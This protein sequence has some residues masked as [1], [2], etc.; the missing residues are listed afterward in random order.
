MLLCCFFPLFLKSDCIFILSLSCTFHDIRP[1]SVWRDFTVS[2]Q[3]LKVHKAT[4]KSRSYTVNGVST[5]PAGSSLAQHQ[6]YQDMAVITY[7]AIQQ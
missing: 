3:P 5:F 6:S 1:L 4:D 2:C 7:L